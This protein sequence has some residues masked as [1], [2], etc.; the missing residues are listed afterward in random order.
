[1]CPCGLVVASATA[2]L[3]TAATRS[4]VGL[5]AS[6]AY[7]CRVAA[8]A[9]ED[10]A[11]TNAVAKTVRMKNPSW[12]ELIDS[13]PL[14]SPLYLRKLISAGNGK[15]RGFSQRR[16]R[17]ADGEKGEGGD[18]STAIVTGALGGGGKRVGLLEQVDADQFRRHREGAFRGGLSMRAWCA[19]RIR[20]AVNGL[21]WRADGNARGQGQVSDG[22]AGMN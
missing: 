12:R 21:A 6:V 17:F 10:S 20:H 16:L 18:R 14:G 1:M 11:A 2:S 9:G 13:I 4:P 5:S 19:V 3:S 22:G 8:L 7:W 15:F